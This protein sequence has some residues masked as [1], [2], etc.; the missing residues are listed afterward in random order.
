MQLRTL[1]VS[2]PLDFKNVGRIKESIK[3]YLINTYIGKCTLENGYITNIKKIKIQDNVISR[4]QPVVFVNVDFTCNVFNPNI[5]DVLKCKTVMMFSEGI[6]TEKQ[7]GES[8][9]ICVAIPRSNI[10]NKW[11]TDKFEGIDIGD[12]INVKITNVNYDG[13]LKKYIGSLLPI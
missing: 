13:I 7:I 2:V 1:H 11:N 4:I 6:W 12:L 9:S 5:G 8:T 3:E 10:Q